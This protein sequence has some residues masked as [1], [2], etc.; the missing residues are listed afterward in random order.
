MILAKERQ[1]IYFSSDSDNTDSKWEKR[2]E[3]M[4]V[5]LILDQFIHWSIQT[6]QLLSKWVRISTHKR[7]KIGQWPRARIR[8]WPIL[9]PPP[10]DKKTDSKEEKLWLVVKTERL[11]LVPPHL[12]QIIPLFISE[13]KP[14]VGSQIRDNL[15]HSVLGYQSW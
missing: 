6:C 14:E 2:R 8:H 5:W 13:W 15:T 7:V 11:Q 9:I 3:L 4:F 10:L 1:L 12:C